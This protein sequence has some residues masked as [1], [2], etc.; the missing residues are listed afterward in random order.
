MND[1]YFANLS[2]QTGIDEAALRAA[3]DAQVSGLSVEDVVTLLRSRGADPVLLRAAAILE[4]YV[5]CASYECCCIQGS[6]CDCFTKRDSS[7]R[8]IPM[9]YPCPKCCGEDCAGCDGCVEATC[10]CDAA[11]RR[12]G[13]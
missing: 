11:E 13:A 1:T 8:E 10:V 5:T 3:S 4:L 12:M 2:A 7:W 9:N 6:C